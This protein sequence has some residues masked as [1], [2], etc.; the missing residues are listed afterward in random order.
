[1][2][3]ESHLDEHLS[4][5]IANIMDQVIDEGFFTHSFEKFHSMNYYFEIDSDWAR[6]NKEMLMVSII[7]DYKTTPEAESKVLNLCNE[8]SKKFQAND[9]I[10][11]AFH[12]NELEYYEEEDRELILKNHQLMKELVRD[13]YRAIREETREKSEEE[14]IASLI[15]EKY[16]F[17]TLKKLSQGPISLED[18][19]DWFREQFPDKDFKELIDT[20][21]DNQ[22][23]F[24]NE[25]GRVEKYVLLLKEVNAERIPPFSVIEY[26]DENPELIALI[27]PEIKEYFSNYILKTK[28]ELLEDSLILFQVLA[29]PK[30][31]NVL[32]ELRDRL[33]SVRK[34]S[35]LVSDKTLTAMNK[36]LD[37][38]R[39]HDIIDELEY[40][41]E[42]YL[43]LKTNI[44]VTTTFPQYLRKL[45]P[46]EIKPVIANKRKKEERLPSFDGK[47]IAGDDQISK[48]FNS[49]G[50]KENLKKKILINNDFFNQQKT[51]ILTFLTKLLILKKKDSTFSR[52]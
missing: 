12:I 7:F 28:E 9:Q 26:I 18:L 35:T 38:L 39:K 15:N 30:K 48:V 44:Q 1:A 45:L 17:L 16:I 52:L 29:D 5:R 36:I 47:N 33:I 32:F 43:F 3:P 8:F 13:L 23:I 34:L 19:E 14:I 20:L 40:Q 22:F 11:T 51:K 6:G 31:Y 24:I 49:R 27:L 10:F 50:S 41:D 4:I 46:K 37:F 21:I 25:I 2:Y 42:K